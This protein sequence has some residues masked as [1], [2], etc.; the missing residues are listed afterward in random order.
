MAEY[1]LEEFVIGGE[2]FSLTTIAF[3]PIEALMANQSKE[4]E[5]SGQ[6]LWCGSLSVAEYLLR[7]REWVVGSTV[8]ELGAGTGVVSML[9]KRLGATSVVLT[10]NDPRS[11]QHM[12]DDCKVNGIVEGALVE[13]LDWF[14]FQGGEQVWRAWGAGTGGSR[15]V[16]AGDVL[17][18]RQL[19]QPFFSTVRQLLSPYAEGVGAEMLL[20]HVPRAGVDHAEV[21]RSAEEHGLSALEVGRE[22][23]CTGALLEYC[24]EED[25]SRARLY[26]IAF[27]K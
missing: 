5:I 11:I 18:K 10:D 9:C 17:Y 6:K 8:V 3:M 24:P 27:V 2:R 26:K 15:R 7:H 23:W 22:L 14:N 21:V 19:L 20:C 1:E 25:T 4:V 12:Q 13:S 16:V